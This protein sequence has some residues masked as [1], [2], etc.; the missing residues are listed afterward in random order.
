MSRFDIEAM[1]DKIHE[2]SVVPESWMPVL[3]SMTEIAGGVGT[4]LL[5]ADTTDFRFISTKGLAGFVESFVEEGWP[6]K[7]TRTPA[8]L[9]ARHAGFIVES[10]VYTP[11]EIERDPLINQFLRP[12]GLGWATATAFPMSTGDTLVFSIE[13]AFRDG[14]VP[15]EAVAI[16]D[17]VRP[18]LGRAALIS[19]RLRLERARAAVETLALLG[20]PAGIIS[21]SSRLQAA[22][23]LLDA[24]IPVTVRDGGTRVAFADGDAD[25]LLAAALNAANRQVPRSIP[26][27]ARNNNPAMVAHL[28]PV[29]GVAR[30]LFTGSAFILVLTPVEANSQGPDAD[31]LQGLFDLTA[32]EARVARAIVAG[33]TVETV[34]LRQ[35]VSESTVRTQL[36]SVF[37]KTGMKGQLDLV[38]LGSGLNLVRSDDV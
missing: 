32:A 19:G 9:R 18:H 25:D 20:L 7:N 5:A 29:R 12:Q 31:L 4:I 33:E 21:R 34:A 27:P 35:G 37:A 24:L 23:G 17:S 30:D 13:R 8:V 1:T 22:N 3:D 11:E 14:P 38:R 36:K 16:L 2:A 28:V 15:P 26:L 6:E 10:D